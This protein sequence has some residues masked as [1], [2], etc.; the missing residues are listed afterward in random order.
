MQKR[1]EKI[2]EPK[3][4]MTDDIKSTRGKQQQVRHLF[5]LKVNGTTKANIYK[6]S[7]N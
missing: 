4:E 7:E 2:M 3:S 6:L 1:D 5:E